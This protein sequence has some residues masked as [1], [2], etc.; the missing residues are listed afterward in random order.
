MK[1]LELLINFYKKCH[2]NVFDALLFGDSFIACIQCA[3]FSI[4]NAKC[5][6][7]PVFYLYLFSSYAFHLLY[8]A[9]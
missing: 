4:A 3:T 6:L 7:Q 1:Y 5:T 8:G 2:L 9:L